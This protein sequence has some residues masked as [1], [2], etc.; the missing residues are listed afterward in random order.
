MGHTIS[1]IIKLTQSLVKTTFTP[2]WLHAHRSDWRVAK[3]VAF[4]YIRVSVH[5]MNSKAKQHV[6]FSFSLS[7]SFVV[8]SVFLNVSLSSTYVSFCP[9]AFLYLCLPPSSLL[10]HT[11]T[12]AC[13][14]TSPFVPRYKNCWRGIIC[15]NMWITS[16]QNRKMLKWQEK[17]SKFI[18]IHE[19]RHK[20]VRDELLL[21]IN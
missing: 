13:S 4:T 21:I 12:C 20:L 6:Q 8:L 18:L 15:E 16:L 2:R 10:H 1:L 7:L 14:R 9:S 5:P 17:V 11:Y 3:E 19:K